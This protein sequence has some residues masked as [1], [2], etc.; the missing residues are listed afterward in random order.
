MPIKLTGSWSI[1]VEE[2]NAGFSQRIVISGSSNN[3]DGVFP[4]T[5]FG[6]KTIKGSFSIQIQYEK[7]T[8]WYDSLMR[9]PDANRN[10]DNIELKIESDD[11]VGTGGDLDF[12]DLILSAKT[13][14]G[15]DDYCVW[16]RVKKYSGIFNPCLFPRLVID[17][18]VIQSPRLPKDIRKRIEPLIAELPPID[19]P[20][21]PDP[22]PW[23]HRAIPVEIPDEVASDL[24]SSSTRA[25]RGA[26]RQPGFSKVANP[27]VERTLNAKSA[28]AIPSISTLGKLALTKKL[29]SWGKCKDPAKGIVLRV[30]D[31]DPGPGEGPTN[32]FFGTGDREILGQTVTDDWGYYFFCFPWT[33]PHVGGLKPDVMLQLTRYDDEG[34]PSVALESSVTWNIDKLHRKDWCIPCHL[35]DPVIPDEFDPGRV[36][37]YIGNLPVVR[38]TN[39]GTGKGYANTILGDGTATNP[40]NL[41]NS[42]F[43]GTLLIKANFK[44]LPGVASYKIRYRTYDN[45]EGNTPWTDLA[46]PLRLYN[47]TWDLE[48][49]GPKPATIEGTATSAYP[50]YEGNVVYSH[51]HGLQYKG[52][53]ST[54][55]IKTGFLLLEIRGYDSS[56]TYVN[57]SFDTVTLRMDNKAPIPEI[58]PVAS[59]EGACGFVEISAPGQKVPITYRT[60]DHEGHLLT[61]FIKIFKCHDTQLGGNNVKLDYDASV[62]GISWTGTP[63]ES[64]SSF[65]GFITRNL[66]VGADI[67][68]AADAATVPNFAALAIELWAYSRTTNGIINSIHKPR[69][70]EVIGVKLISSTP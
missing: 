69:Y 38:I 55:F 50:N 29:L 63:E 11:N 70:V 8:V 48:T 16:G 1:K 49:V 35:A 21:L 19:N 24:L 59:G 13:T 43:G 7:G 46:T 65:D 36:L 3:K 9:V 4:Y 54:G 17:D 41:V 45:P 33:Y 40:L 23:D 67:F 30:V 56:G 14:V 44:N 34:I 68:T 27:A 18:W 53:I 47:A 5:S 26:F 57:D 22:P 6:T 2:K 37:Q 20:P 60:I 42:P 15:S 25:R 12:N 61:T 51:P 31:Y 52:Y 10:G 66:P 64:D 32:P 39:I 62:Y 58:L 28:S